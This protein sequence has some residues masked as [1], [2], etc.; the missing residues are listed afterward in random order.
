MLSNAKT[1][2]TQKSFHKLW[3]M[4]IFVFCAITFEPIKI[5]KCLAP[6]NH[7]L[8]LSFGKKITKSGLEMAIYHSKTF[9]IET[10]FI[11]VFFVTLLTIIRSRV[12]V[13]D[14]H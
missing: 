2:K 1:H 3:E 11:F 4:E 14:N 13:C 9:R 12:A 5:Q 10:L 7:C 6:H 8:N